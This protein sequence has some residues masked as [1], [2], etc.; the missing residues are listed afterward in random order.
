M[1]TAA[2]NL[3]LLKSLDFTYF[4]AKNFMCFGEEGIEIDL[5]KYGNILLKIIQNLEKKHI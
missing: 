4:S 2:N 3:N 5:K 1:F